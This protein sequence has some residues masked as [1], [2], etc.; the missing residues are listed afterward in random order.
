VQILAPEPG[1]P[2][3]MGRWQQYLDFRIRRASAFESKMH[4]VPVC[5]LWLDNRSSAMRHGHCY[6]GSYY[7]CRVAY[8]GHT[9]GGREIVLRMVMEEGVIIKIDVKCSSAKSLVTSW[10]PF[11]TPPHKCYSIFPC[12]GQEV[13]LPSHIGILSTELSMFASLDHSDCS[14]LKWRPP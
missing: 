6:V 11:F 5:K 9:R 14:R 4:T 8:R 2:M 7:N 10:L 3:R 1:V 12:I 13:I